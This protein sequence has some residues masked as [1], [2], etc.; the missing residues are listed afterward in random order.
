MERTWRKKKEYEALVGCYGRDIIRSH[1]PF[2]RKT[3]MMKLIQIDDLRAPHSCVGAGGAAVLI[4]V[5][6]G[7][8]LLSTCFIL[9]IIKE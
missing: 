7:A 4:L 8:L 6:P 1:S 9:C 3:V 2:S 5:I